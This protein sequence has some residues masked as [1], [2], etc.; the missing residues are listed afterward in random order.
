MGKSPFFAVKTCTTAP[1]TSSSSFV[2]SLLLQLLNA[3]RADRLVRDLDTWP[4]L[5]EGWKGRPTKSVATNGYLLML[6]I[7]RSLNVA[8]CG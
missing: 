1:R 3:A 8:A 5:P 4:P 2:I 7:N 6:S